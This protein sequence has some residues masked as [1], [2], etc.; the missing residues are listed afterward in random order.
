MF[1]LFPCRTLCTHIL[2]LA[3][4]LL[5]L[6]VQ[7]HERKANNIKTV[8][9]GCLSGSEPV[10]ISW[11]YGAALLHNR[12][13]VL[14]V[15]M[16]HNDLLGP[17]VPPEYRPPQVSQPSSAADPHRMWRLGFLCLSGLKRVRYVRWPDMMAS[18]AS[19]SPDWPLNT[20]RHCSFNTIWQACKS[21]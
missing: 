5:R 11:S 18:L 2:A 9:S 1:Y 21:I 13:L 12:C 14:I 10:N 17:F 7:N 6:D 19:T 15:F 16:E 8:A 4:H 3:H 20:Q